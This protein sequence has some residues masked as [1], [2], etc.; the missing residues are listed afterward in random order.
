[1]REFQNEDSEF[2]IDILVY[3]LNQEFNYPLL[4]T[5]YINELFD[6]SNLKQVISKL[7]KFSVGKKKPLIVSYDSR[8]S[9][10]LKKELKKN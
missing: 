4:D 5:I 9:E 3:E 1:M 2:K 6:S 7:N 10:L 8:I